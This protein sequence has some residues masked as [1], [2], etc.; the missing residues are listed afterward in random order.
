MKTIGLILSYNAPTITD[1][2][3][4]S[5]RSVVK[6][7]F[8]LVVLDNGSD[9][10]KISK[11]ATHFI[12]K[13]CRMTRGF[14]HGLRE[15]ESLYP[16]YDN[17]WLFTSDCYFDNSAVCPVQSTHAYLN[18]YPRIGILHPSLHDS[19]KVCYDVKN[20][21]ATKGLKIVSEYDFVCPLFT[22][23]AL[24]AIGGQFNKD[25]YQGWGIDFESSFMVRAS[26]MRVAI[27]HDIIVKHDTSW[28]YDHGLDAEH[29]NRDAY[30][31]AAGL[32]MRQVFTDKYGANW[33][34]IFTHNHNEEV[35]QQYE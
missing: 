33:H 1:R 30:Y 27:N 21:G 17:V 7:E 9:K 28:T 23:K 6:T 10:D 26:G 32:E 18:K 13:N 20:D 16:D 29:G 4:D 12:L 34:F 22:R 35:G 11:Y 24:D 5:I 19:V 15:V 14:N 25:L 2:L 8:P 3:V 31:G